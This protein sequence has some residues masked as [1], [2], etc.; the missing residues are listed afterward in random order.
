MKDIAIAVAA[1]L[2]FA[3]G[4][5]VEGWRK[6]AEIDRLEANHLA[7][8]AASATASANRLADAQKRG[9]DLQFRLAK[10]EAINYQLA[11]EKDREIRRLTFGRPCLG[12][13]AIRVLNESA[14][15]PAAALP[16]TSGQL[17][18]SDA[19]FATDTDVGVWIGQCRRGYDACRN[20][21]EA[22]AEFE[23]KGGND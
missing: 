2:I 6:D 10:S 8:I 14:G 7:A 9:N 4:W 23:A 11:Q 20:R 17:L 21:L 18:R 22:I 13:A 3:S 19:A 1:A 12:S 16:Q 5:L 15:Q